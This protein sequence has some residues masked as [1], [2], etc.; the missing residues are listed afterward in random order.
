[1]AMKFGI[2]AAIALAGITLVHAPSNAKDAG[3]RLQPCTARVVYSEE[4]PFAPIDSWLVKATLEITTQNGDSYVM[5]LQDRMPWQG[6]PPRRGQAFRL[7]CN[8]ARP[9][10]LRMIARSAPRSSH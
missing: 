4:L 2:A 3:N 9:D 7:L 10:D 8:P 5:T 1:M 6:A